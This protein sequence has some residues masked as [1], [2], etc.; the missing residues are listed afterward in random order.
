MGVSSQT[1]G[2]GGSRVVLVTAQRQA[3]GGEGGYC[4]VLRSGSTNQCFAACFDFKA[5]AAPTAS[6]TGESSISELQVLYT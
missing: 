1:R 6:A 5:H 3:H 2:G 4:R